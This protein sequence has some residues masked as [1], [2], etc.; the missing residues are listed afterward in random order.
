MIY[1]R[2][3]NYRTIY[4][5]MKSFFFRFVV[6]ACVFQFIYS[7]SAQTAVTETVRLDG[8]EARV[9]VRRDARSVPYIV[10]SSD[11]DLY[12][13]QGFVTASDRLWQMDLLR[14]SARGE[15]AEIFGRTVFEQD[16]KY[17]LYGFAAWADMAVASCSPEYRAALESYASGVNAFLKTT[18]TEDLPPEFRVLGY[19][20]RQWTIS[21][22]LVVGRLFAVALGET[23][24]DDA[25]RASVSDVAPEKQAKMFTSKSPF[26]MISIGRD[27]PSAETKRRAESSVRISDEAIHALN[28][29]RRMTQDSLRRIGLG[30]R[31]M[32]ISNAWAVSGK[33]TIS[34]KPLLANDP[35]LFPS[36]PSIWYLTY[37]NSPSQKV[38]GA[39]TP[40]IP[41]I[42]IGRN[43]DIAW[44][45]TNLRADTQDLV[46]IKFTDESHDNY[47]TADS[48]LKVEKTIEKIRV[49]KGFT[50]NETEEI[51]VTLARTKFGPIFYEQSNESYALNWSVLGEKSVDSEAFSSIN[52][53]K[54]YRQWRAAL[55]R[56]KGQ[57][58]S[59]VYA[60]TQGN[61]AYQAAGTVPLREKGDGT[62]P[63]ASNELKSGFTGTTAFSALPSLYNPPLGIIVSANNRMVST[64]YPVLL[65]KMWIPPYRAKRIFDLLNVDEK[66]TPEKFRAIQADTFSVADSLFIGELKKAVKKVGSSDLQK[67]I[68]LIF[69]DSEPI[70][71]ANSRQIALSYTTRNIFAERILIFI[72]GAE[73]AKEADWTAQSSFIDNILIE[74]PKEFLPPEFASYERLLLVCYE[75][76]VKNLQKTIGDDRSLWTWGKLGSY[77]FLHPLGSTPF[78]GQQFAFA[79][80]PQFAG[81]SGGT[82]NAGDQVSMRMIIDLSNQDSLQQT[83]ATGQSGNSRSKYYND[84]FD[85]WRN[86]SLK[87]IYVNGEMIKRKTETMLELLPQRENRK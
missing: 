12:F 73:R 36:A 72:L 54:D 86:G 84:Q 85:D 71:S 68:A 51:P 31:Q 87:D 74:K 10:A 56:Y 24:Y 82:V 62:L 15:L 69:D 57:P 78:V 20:P 30:S 23:W 52:R 65:S 2:L 61:I 29:A 7:V 47:R 49:R 17:R 38:A 27:Q 43:A 44:G 41:G 58:Q 53:A 14:R 70:T 28:D 3:E 76:A 67:E 22:S 50:G 32:A 6:S 55:A 77:K 59:F 1:S 45:I 75:D 40:G 37:L 39:A 60:D 66:M 18:R 11:R 48:V 64:D 4:N 26:D 81:G 8:P 46:S 34:G 16:K 80:I 9:T 21:D 79:S 83:L 63:F 13:A 25:F 35:H 42:I 33:R 19:Q 5:F